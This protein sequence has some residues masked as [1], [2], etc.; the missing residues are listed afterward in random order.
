MIRITSLQD[1]FRR[2][3]VAHSCEDTEYRDNFF[4]SDQLKTLR[5][6]PMLLVEIIAGQ[7]G[8]QPLNVAKTV[9][10]VQAAATLEEL[11]T[12]AEGETR[13]GVLDAI[14]KRRTELEG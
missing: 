4:T 12:L 2:C 9:E 6:E 7:N 13:K 8:G 11:D 3:G 10:Q 14:T 5:E 1:G